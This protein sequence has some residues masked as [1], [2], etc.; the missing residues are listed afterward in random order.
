MA[1]GKAMTFPPMSLASAGPPHSLHRTRS[2]RFEV[3]S[4]ASASDAPFTTTT[5]AAGH[6]PLAENG[7]PS[8]TST[9]F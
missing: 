1:R 4:P 9:N 8:W 3:W 5:A 2:T 7:A 6:S